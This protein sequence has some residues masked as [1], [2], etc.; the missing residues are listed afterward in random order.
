MQHDEE[1][2]QADG[3]G[4][5][6]GLM[7]FI[8][9]GGFGIFLMFA[10]AFSSIWGLLRAAYDSIYAGIRRMMIDSSAGT[11]YHSYSCRA[12][13]VVS[14]VYAG[15]CVVLLMVALYVWG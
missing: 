9:A 11:Q 15:S 1:Q 13:R 10:M 3:I 12:C 8:Y 6:W 7:L 2:Q 4:L 14:M 5:F